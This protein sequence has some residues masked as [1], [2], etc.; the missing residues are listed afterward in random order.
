VNRN[1]IEIEITSDGSCLTIWNDEN[2]MRAIGDVKVT[3]LSDIEFDNEEQG[4]RV[5]FR[6]GVT[7]PGLYEKRIEALNAEIDYAEE[8]MSEFGE[9]VISQHPEISNTTDFV[10]PSMS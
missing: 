1:D 10:D 2:C 8:H 4:W 3:R 6:N 5:H 7:L 9:W